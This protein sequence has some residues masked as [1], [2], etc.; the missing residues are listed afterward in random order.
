MRISAKIIRGGGA[1]AG[2]TLVELMIVLVIVGLIAAVAMTVYLGYSRDARSAEARALAGSV[3]KVL[4]GCAQARGS[5][6]TC[7]LPDIVGRV[8][9]S[10]VGLTGD[11]RWRVGTADLSIGKGSGVPTMSGTITVSGT[12]GR[13]TDGV[14]LGIYVSNVGVV[15]RCTTLSPTPPPVDSG[16][17][18]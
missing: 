12:A 2:F 7:S 3:L 9:V 16:D 10:S 17:A 14:A 6:G 8:S 13:D 15:L 11:G 1:R 18:C 5:G 4:E